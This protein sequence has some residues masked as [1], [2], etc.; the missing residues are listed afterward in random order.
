MSL[1]T[2][3][4]CASYAPDQQPWHCHPPFGPSSGAADGMPP[5]L[6]I[7]TLV[8]LQ[9]IGR[10]AWNRLEEWMQAERAAAP[11]EIFAA[12]SPQRARCQALDDMLP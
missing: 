1:P 6:L 2:F 9:A 12:P 5:A 3:P 10:F 11:P 4:G 7:C 8:G